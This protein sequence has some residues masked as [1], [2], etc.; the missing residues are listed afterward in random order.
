M[1]GHLVQPLVSLIV[2]NWNGGRYLEECLNSILNQSYKPTEILIVD[3]ASSDDSHTILEK[4]PSIRLIQN[5]SNLG[6]GPANNQGISAA[7]GEIIAFINNDVVL[8]PDWLGNIVSVLLSSENIG[9]CAGKTLSYFQKDTIDNTGHLLFWDGINRGRGR[10]QK[11][12]G[13]FDEVRHAFFPSGSACV[14][15]TSAFQQIGTFD[16]DFFLYGDDAEIGIRAR[17]AGWEC[18]FVPNAVAY[19]RYSASSS[20]YDPMKFFYV[21]RNRF[22]VVLKYFPLELVLLNPVFSMVRYLFHFVAMLRG[23]GVSG[24]FVQS[25]PSRNLF[26]LWTKAQISAW[27]EMPRFWRKRKE[28]WKQFR[29]SR[30]RFYECFLP[31][32]I[33]VRELTFTP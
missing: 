28:L 2:V 5:R 1:G 13:Q 18:A 11:D 23:K 16:E 10:M 17:L 26:L 33:G 6:Y 21:E 32:R 7:R 12:A 19:H 15:K 8:D 30:K 24:Q 29:W 3:N 9:M 31:N 4:F 20:P 27:K 22:W 14:F 25:Y